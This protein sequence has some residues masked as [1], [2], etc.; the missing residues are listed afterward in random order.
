MARLSRKFN[1]T[2]IPL[3]ASV[4]LIACHAYGWSEEATQVTGIQLTPNGEIV[5]QVS[6]EGFDPQFQV[7]PLPG[8]QYQIT[9]SGKHVTLGNVRDE[10]LDEAFQREIPAIQDSMLS[11]TSN[12]F[13]LNLTSWQRLLP[14]IQSNSGDKIV[15]TL[16]GDHR[17]PPEVIARQKRETEQARLAEAKR[18]ADELA[19]QQAALEKKRA[20]EEAAQRQKAAA[21]AARQEALKKRQAEEFVQKQAAETA[22]KQ[23]KAREEGRGIAEA[24]AREQNRMPSVS[25]GN[26]PIDTDWQNA[27][28]NEPVALQASEE[29]SSRQ[30]MAS[31]YDLAFPRALTLPLNPDPLARDRMPNPVLSDESEPFAPLRLQKTPSGYDPDRTL[32]ESD[33]FRAGEFGL[34]SEYAA[35]TDPV[36]QRI[37]SYLRNGEADRA[38]LELRSRLAQ[39]PDDVESR[40]LL[41]LILEQSARKASPTAKAFDR[42]QLENARLE[43]VKITNQRPFLPAYLKLA[44]WYLDESTLIEARR[45]LDQMTPLYPREANVWFLQGRLSEAENNI[46]EA[47]TAYLKALALQPRQP[48]FHYRLA[49]VHLKSENRDACRWELLRALAISP[50]DARCWKLL[51]YLA[52][53][54]GPPEQAIQWYQASL[55]PDVMI[56]Y[57]RLL[58]KRNQAKEALAIY[59]A[60][61]SIAGEDLDLL[62]NLGMIYVDAQQARR[63]EAVLK[64]FIRL[65]ANPSDTRIAQAKNVLKQLNR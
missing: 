17:L 18:K 49:Q 43:L 31:H 57:G 44:D 52:E 33:T 20:A 63:A 62:F 30:Q 3:A 41:A 10:R 59:Q 36:I 16:I 35:S 28:R 22:L 51:G 61:E 6:G 11:G 24:K 65:N 34:Y 53:K 50:D 9:I 54:Q 42:T 58:E 23:E 14:Q 48:E 26:A 56:H 13:Q 40:Y 32:M 8:E 25:P 12:G 47:K 4:L 5:L 19:K 1:T 7:R 46:S 45:V 37:R 29:N 15:I 38:E 27:Y 21:E 55:Q 64:R 2:L 60:V 39:Q